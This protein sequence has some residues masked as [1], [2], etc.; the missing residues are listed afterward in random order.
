MYSRFVIYPHQETKTLLSAHT[1]ESPLNR[2]NLT[3]K[4]ASIVQLGGKA[5]R[6]ITYEI[7]EII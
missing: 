7:K 5:H 6:T 2:C 4:K 3:P 1:I